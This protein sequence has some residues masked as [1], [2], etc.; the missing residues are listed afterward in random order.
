[1]LFVDYSSAFNTV[2]PGKL[3]IK[4]HQLGLSSQ[5][6]NWIQDFL[7]E[8]PQAVRLGPHTSSTISLSTGTPQGCVLSPI[9]YSLFT[10][11]CVPEFHN[12]TIVK[13]ADDTTVVGLITDDDETAY[14]A[15]IHKL[16]HWCSENDLSLN[17]GKTKELVINF[18]KPKATDFTLIFI[19]GENVESIQHQVPGSSHI[20]GPHMDYTHH[21]ASEKGT[22]AAVLPEDT[23]EGRATTKDAGN[24]LSLLRREHLDVLHFSVVLQ[25]L[26]SGQE[27]TSVHGIECTENNWN[28]TPRAG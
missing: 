9:L 25:L 18:R 19:G 10:H 8:R 5:L 14:R 6:C 3:T 4:L 21:D 2:I 22:A 7:T 26:S 13:F 20:R 28:S 1:M 16:V 17:A 27:G 23:E 15:E 11:E 24:L 12:N